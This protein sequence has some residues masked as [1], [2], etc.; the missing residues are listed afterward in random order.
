MS[1]MRD[2]QDT[3]VGARI[4]I[5]GFARAAVI[6]AAFCVV[7]AS[8]RAVQNVLA[9]LVAAMFFSLVVITPVPWLSR[10]MPRWLAASLVASGTTLMVGLVIALIPGW[11]T[12]LTEIY[13]LHQDTIG[14]IPGEL[15]GALQWA[16]VE[17]TSMDGGVSA[18]WLLDASARAF[19]LVSGTVFVLV[20][21]GFVV[22]ELGG[23]RTKVEAA[24]GPDSPRLALLDRVFDRLV[25]YFLIKSVASA[26]TGLLVAL[27]CALLGLPVPELWG[28]IAFLLN[29]APTIGSFVAAVPAVLLAFLTL[30]WWQ[31]A[32]LGGAFL[33]INITIGS[34]IEPKVLGE[35]MGLSPL[36]VLISLVFWGWILGPIGLLLAVPLT[37]LFKLVLEQTT[38][39][40]PI[41][42]LLG[43]AREARR[44]IKRR[45]Q[46]SAPA[47][48][49]PPDPP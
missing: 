40:K 39:L 14:A 25:G 13:V 31:A 42:V 6:A 38:G 19:R 12:V 2:P 46:R 45:R 34:I 30:Q 11:I 23:L 32:L 7:A 22:S 29:Y 41:A 26:I 17:Q 5:D 33:V 24:V 43:G 18:Q 47:T 49:P 27:S 35:R 36:V 44:T 4:T 48:A 9:P 16:G 1:S 8:L 15:R 37:M 28:L 20:L 10:R 21:L 3:L